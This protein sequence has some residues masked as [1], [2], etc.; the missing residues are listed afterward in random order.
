[1]QFFYLADEK[2]QV[3]KADPSRL[4]V[5]LSYRNVGYVFR[6]GSTVKAAARPP[7]SKEPYSFA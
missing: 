5:N 1:M 2:P 3:P 4:R 6:N 7:H